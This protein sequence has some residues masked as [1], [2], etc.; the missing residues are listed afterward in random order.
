MHQKKCFDKNNVDLF[1]IEH[2]GNSQYVLT[3][4]CN[5]F[6]YDRILHRARKHFCPFSLPA[7]IRVET[8]KGYF[9]DYFKINAKQMILTL[10]KGEYFRFKNY[11]RKIK[12]PFTIYR[13][14]FLIISRS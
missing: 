11:E 7:F 3:K 5:T 8:L 2:V 14:F 6:M 12:L 9:I 1:L 13:I 10:K 4:N